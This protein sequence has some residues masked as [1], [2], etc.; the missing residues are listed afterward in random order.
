MAILYLDISKY[1]EIAQ[2]IILTYKN[3]DIDLQFPLSK[4]F[5]KRYINSIHDKEFLKELMKSRVSK[6]LV[7]AFVNYLE[8]NTNSIIL[9]KDIILRLCENILQMKLEDLKQEWGLENHISKLIIFLYDKTINIDKQT[10]DKC[11][12]LWDIMFERQLGSVREISQKL[13]ER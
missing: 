6:K 9:Y 2:K 13:M 3:T 5:N 12:D 4:I 7:R 10:S 8:E 1:K 11:M